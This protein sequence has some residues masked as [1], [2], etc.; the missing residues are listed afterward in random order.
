MFAISLGI[1]SNV[2]KTVSPVFALIASAMLINFV[3]VPH[4][5]YPYTFGDSCAATTPLLCAFIIVAL[6]VYSPQCNTSR[7]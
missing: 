2:N 3:S 5:Q 1:S 6:Y 7:D 4:Q